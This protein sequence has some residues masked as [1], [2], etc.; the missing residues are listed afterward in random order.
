M[1]NVRALVNA[2]GLDATVDP[3]DESLEHLARADLFECGCAVTYH[4]ANDLFPAYRAGELSVEE[5]AYFRCTGYRFGGNVGVDRDGDIA[6]RCPVQRFLQSV[7][8]ALHQRGME[9]AADDE[10]LYHL[11]S[12][13]LGQL[14][15]LLHAR[16]RS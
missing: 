9:G 8:G 2:G 1:L 13:L 12:A 10:G 4:V 14:H 16:H 7:P 5:I 11:C 3:L 15:G 6:N